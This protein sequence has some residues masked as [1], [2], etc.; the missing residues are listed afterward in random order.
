MG[1][2]SEHAGDSARFIQTVQY[3]ADAGNPVAGGA[4]RQINTPT[5]QV[6]SRGYADRK[7]RV[8]W[9]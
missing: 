4:A 2:G 6:T 3:P 5:R 1:S 8:D 7:G 9:D